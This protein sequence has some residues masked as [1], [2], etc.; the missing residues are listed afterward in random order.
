MKPDKIILW[1]AKSQFEST[2]ILPKRLLNLQERGLTIRFCADLRSHKKYFYAMQEYPED[3]I[4]LADDDM[5]YPRDTIEKLMKMHNKYPKDIC[6]M[7]AQVITPTFDSAPSVWRN[8]KVKERFTH[9]DRIQVFTGSGSLFPPNS[10]SK[11]AFDEKMILHLCPYADDL[12]LTYMAYL[13]G[14]RFTVAE[15]WRAFPV[16]IYGTSEG[17]LWYLNGQDGKND[18]QWEAIIGYYGKEIKC[19]PK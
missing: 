8:P 7:S 11:N 15:P 3:I 6:T 14:T 1:L 13:N 2:D 12:W 16:A 5:F 4:I 10:I 17:S 9:S 18:E 19:A